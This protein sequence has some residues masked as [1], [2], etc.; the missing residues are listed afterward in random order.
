[1]LFCA[2]RILGLQFIIVQFDA[3]IQHKGK[4]KQ[5]QNTEQYVFSVYYICKNLQNN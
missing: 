4:W 2:N 1:M 3:I 5:Q